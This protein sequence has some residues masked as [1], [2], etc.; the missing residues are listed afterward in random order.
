[1]SVDEYRN[2]VKG[3]QRRKSKYNAKRSTVNDISFDSQHEADRY[4]E[5][6]LLEKA[7][8]ITALM[9]QVPFRLPGPVYYY[10]DF[11]Y[12]DVKKKDW[13]TEDAKGVRTDVYKLKAKQVLDIYGIEILET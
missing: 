10:A 6:K 4:G 8:E 1:M 5:L 3:G 2:F 11:V 12:Y 7:G 9:L 13:I